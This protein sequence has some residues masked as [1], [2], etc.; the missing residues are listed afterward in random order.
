MEELRR[1][2][3]Y[4]LRA[5][6]RQPTFALAAALTMA[7]GIGAN[8]AVF[9]LVRAVLL[10]P[11]PFEQPDRLVT[12]H[13]TGPDRTNQPFS[14]PDFLDLREQN[15]TLLGL[16]GYGAWGAN[17][18]GPAEAERLAGMWATP[19]FLKLL[20]VPPVLGRA[21]LPE[22]ERGGGARV[23]VLT[24]GLWQRLFGGEEAVLGRSMS[25]NGEAYTV[26][27]VLPP[28]FVL[29]GREAELMVPLVVET[30]ARRELRLPAFLRVVA[31]LGPGVTREQAQSELT[32]IARRLQSSYP[33]TNAARTGVKVAPLH[34]EIVGNV[35]LMLAVV[36]GAV[37]LVLLVACANLASLLLARAASR[38][39]EMSVRVALGAGRGR[40]VRQLLTESVLL[41]MVGG[42]LGLLFAQGA[43][44][45]FL[46]LGPTDLPR[47]RGVGLD[48]GVVAF[49]VTLTLLAGV[50]FGL[51]PALQA[52]RTDQQETLAGGGRGSSGSRRRTRARRALVLSEVALSL[53]LLAGAGLLVKSFRRLQAV[54]PGY[55]TA[56]LLTLRVSLPRSRYAQRESLAEFHD[57]LSP[58][59][60]AIP[61]VRAVGA[62][63]VA[64]LTPWR[65]SINF[66]VEGQPPPAPENVPLANYRAVD[67]HYFAAM[68]I[69]LLR[70]RA[71]AAADTVA[72]VPVAVVNRS[73]AER[74][75][76]GGDP[77]GA[78][79]TIDD[80]PNKRTV[81]VVGVVGDVKHYALDEAPSLDVYVPYVQAPQSVAVWLANST[82]WV[83][84][85][86]VDPAGLATAVRQAVRSVDAE[87]AAT[88][89]QSL[90]DA[91]AGT[92]APRRFN[93]LLLE[94]FALG[95]LLLAATGIYAVT[96]YLATQRTRELG[97]RL[98]L[99]ARRAQIL[100]LVMKQGM[101]PAAGGLAVG[102][103][104]SLALARLIEG[105]LY[106]VP[107]RD[108]VTFTLAPLLLAAAS[109][110]ACSLPAFRATRIDP[111]RA[112]RVE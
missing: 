36:Q 96:A 6:R 93:V 60:Q 103:V 5:W 98:A 20:G 80:T 84:R 17:L 75:W 12:L 13:S 47:A 101:A 111:V 57:R 52:S 55:R 23:V 95:A 11:L 73:L 91:L 1:D 110:A 97:I 71:F 3:A 40:L 46:A 90:D 105:L 49:T 45:A 50:A 10:R 72:A 58:R 14:L 66:T 112:L 79:L 102:L 48:A 15:R 107:A 86:S 65:A 87:V 81:E 104:G 74:F 22:E 7:L 56:Q 99:G 28:G 51:V 59:L 77:V 24:H 63:S 109:A 82:S 29:P 19:G 30:D 83:L 76:P 85:T 33:E 35:R 39:R 41:A 70:G 92:V 8:V 94:A 69:P 43:I 67:E 4:G 37:G 25:L 16:V 38:Q 78:R 31:R 44:R 89:I 108:P 53:V 26:I 27:G 62:A 106:G 88:A 68:E 18:T 64:P 2:L 21:P 9:S 32:A 42:A 34:E 100:S 54:D 61:G